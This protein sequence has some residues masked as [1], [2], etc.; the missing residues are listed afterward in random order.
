MALTRG[1]AFILGNWYNSKKGKID[2]LR[3]KSMH[4]KQN[5]DLAI[6]I[7]TKERQLLADRERAL[8]RI[9]PLAGSSFDP[10]PK[11]C[12]MPD[13]RADVV[14]RLMSFAVSED[15]SRR[16]FFLSG[17]AGCGKSSVAT[18]VA[19]ALRQRGCLSG[20]FFF[21][22]DSEKLRIP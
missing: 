12:C 22:R 18:S 17:V 20:S 9:K 7:E 16:L 8:N 19:N 13:T 11:N 5:V 15:S 2:A 3:E 21:K 4:L 10:D 1:P 6:S 14:E